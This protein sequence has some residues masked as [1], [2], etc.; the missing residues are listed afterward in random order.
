MCIQYLPKSPR[1]SL[2]IHNE[3]GGMN[4]VK[5]VDYPKTNMYLKRNRNIPN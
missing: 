4:S 1:V 2:C 3:S 5:R